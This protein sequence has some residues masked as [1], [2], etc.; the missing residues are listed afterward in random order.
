MR[1]TVGEF[2]R[3][4]GWS[5]GVAKSTEGALGFAWDK[6]AARVLE[7]E[8]GGWVMVTGYRRRAGSVSGG[9]KMKAERQMRC[10]Q[11]RVLRCEGQTERAPKPVCTSVH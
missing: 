2:P 4:E 6:V 7:W 9:K 3:K 11:V 5:R 1:V 10:V 8:T